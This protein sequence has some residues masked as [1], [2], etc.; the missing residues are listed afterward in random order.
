MTTTRLTWRVE[1][2]PTGPYRSFRKRGWPTATLPD[3]RMAFR[4]RC[5]DEYVPVRV[6]SGAH[7][8]I[9][10]WVADY[11]TGHSFTWRCLR[12]RGPT[13]DGAKKI[14]RK[15]AECHPEIFEKEID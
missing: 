4:L 6:R 8:P 2:A 12:E 3:G 11:R 7:R 9:A 15:F 10:V 1:E 5:E 14:A 13:L